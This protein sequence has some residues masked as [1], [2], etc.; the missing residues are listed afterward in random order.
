MT[1]F[2]RAD[3]GQ[4]ADHHDQQNSTSLQ[5]L[6]SARLGIRRRHEVL[7]AV[8]CAMPRHALAE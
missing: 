2:V 3:G 8:Q 6:L 7:A 1:L 4:T 5:Q